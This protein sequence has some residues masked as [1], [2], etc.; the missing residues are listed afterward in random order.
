MN[1][2]D[3]IQANIVEQLEAEENLRRLE[4]ERIALVEELAANIEAQRVKNKEEAE[5]YSDDDFDLW[6]AT[7]GRGAM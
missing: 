5:G 7:V 3:R 2:R 4:A 6:Y 1:E